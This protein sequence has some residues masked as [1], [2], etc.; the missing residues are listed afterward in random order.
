MSVFARL[1]RLF[2][3]MDGPLPKET[4]MLP[5]PNRQLNLRPVVFHIRF[6]EEERALD[7]LRLLHHEKDH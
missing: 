4:R 6:D 7:R 2:V 3:E 1:V 5:F